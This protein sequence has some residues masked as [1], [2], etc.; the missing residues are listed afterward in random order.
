MLLFVFISFL[1]F[2]WSYFSLAQ[3]HTQLTTH[4]DKR[5]KNQNQNKNKDTTKTENKKTMNPEPCP[6]FGFHPI[7]KKSLNECTGGCWVAQE[8]L[9]PFKLKNLL[10]SI[11][12]DVLP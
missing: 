3:L 1:F 2:C 10:C 8:G 5:K 9:R 6:G 4:K 7:Q 12:E 11:E